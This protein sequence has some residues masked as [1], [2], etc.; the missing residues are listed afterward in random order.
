M[1]WNLNFGSVSLRILYQNLFYDVAC[2]NDGPA[3][4]TLQEPT[5]RAWL[6]DDL[7]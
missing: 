4:F 6:D 5:K 7:K 3:F 1:K 2:C